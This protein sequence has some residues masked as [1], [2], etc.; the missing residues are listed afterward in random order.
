MNLTA[1]DCTPTEDLVEDLKEIS[2]DLRKGRCRHGNTLAELKQ[3]AY[4]TYTCL[5]ERGHNPRVSRDVKAALASAK[6][7]GK[8]LVMAARFA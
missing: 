5:R 8:V 2:H 1:F 7:K 3:E 4:E 6:P